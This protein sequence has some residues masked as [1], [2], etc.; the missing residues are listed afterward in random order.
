MRQNF[1][2]GLGSKFP[3]AGTVNEVSKEA[4]NNVFRYRRW[5]GLF[6]ACDGNYSTHALVLPDGIYTAEDL[7]QQ[8]R[9]LSR[10]NGHGE[11]TFYFGRVDDTIVMFINEMGFQ[12]DFTHADSIGKFLG[13]KE[14]LYPSVGPTNTTDYS[15]YAESARGNLNTDSLKPVETATEVFG[16]DPLDFKLGR[17]HTLVR[18]A[19]ALGRTRLWA[20]GSNRYGQL[21][22]AVNAGTDLSNPTP[23]LIREFDEMNGGSKVASFEAGGEHSMVQTEGGELW[24][25]GSNRYGQLGMPEN[26]GKTFPN[27]KPVVWNHTKGRHLIDSRNVLVSDFR[28]G[29]DHTMVFLVDGDLGAASVFSFGSNQYGQLARPENAGLCHDS[30]VIRPCRAIFEETTDAESLVPIASHV[31]RLVTVSAQS[32]NDDSNLDILDMRTGGL[33]SIVATRDGRLWCAGSNQYGQCGSELSINDQVTSLEYP[34][35]ENNAWGLKLIGSKFTTYRSGVSAK[36][37]AVSPDVT[38]CA[39]R[40]STYMDTATQIAGCSCPAGEWLFEGTCVACPF[41]GR[42][43]RSIIAGNLHS[44][45]A[46]DDGVW[47]S[48]GSNI[49]G[50]LLRTSL[51]LGLANPGPWVEAIERGEHSIVRKAV[52][53]HATSCT[54][55]AAA[56]FTILDQSSS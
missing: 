13:F 3:P 4:G 17:T 42:S 30:Q 50:Q 45:V 56:H 51:N 33:H 39:P 34:L 37:V 16:D 5:C 2:F 15:F 1:G 7:Y 43:I 18:T 10:D 27:S 19:D 6:P 54:V 12:V 53:P 26:A 9:I 47:W 32:Q 31:P 22:S 36:R 55:S 52:D 40:N 20:F 29:G 14:G 48:F 21:G 44:I 28:L 24:V 25:F 23:H 41:A 46:T 11:F 35:Y 49:G 8:V 38:C